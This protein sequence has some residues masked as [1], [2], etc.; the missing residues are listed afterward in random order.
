[1]SYIHDHG[2]NLWN[3][4]DSIHIN[5]LYH[6]ASE[7]EMIQIEQKFRDSRRTKPK[8]NLFTLI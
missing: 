3:I 2:L 5:Y 4:P 1:M 7:L 8:M 6:V